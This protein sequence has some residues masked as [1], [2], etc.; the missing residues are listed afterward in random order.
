MCLQW[1]IRLHMAEER[2][3]DSWAYWYHVV[4]GLLGLA[5]LFLCG[6][7]DPAVEMSFWFEVC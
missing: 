1:K 6:V 5:E 3:F 4:R 7:M 2:E